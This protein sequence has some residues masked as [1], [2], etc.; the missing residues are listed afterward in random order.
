MPADVADVAGNQKCEKLQR[1][2]PVLFKT[3][4]GPS[5]PECLGKAERAVVLGALSDVVRFDHL[6]D[7]DW[8]LLPREFGRQPPARDQSRAQAADR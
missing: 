5:L 7:V 2:L 3:S 4:S 1:R 8:P 6:A